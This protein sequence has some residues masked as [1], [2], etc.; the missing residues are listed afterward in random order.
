MSDPV[1]IGTAKVLRNTGKALLVEIDGEEAWVPK[2][3]IHDNSEV[4]SGQSEPG[5]LIVEAWW[6]RLN[7]FGDG[8]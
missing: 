2:S 8:T 7:G 1:S 3:V 6:A 5:E 4:Y